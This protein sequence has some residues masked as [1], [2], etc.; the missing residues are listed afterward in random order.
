MAYSSVDEV[1]AFTRHLL[2][3]Q[4]SYNEDTTPTLAEVQNF[5][6]QVSA[7]LDTALA[8]EGFTTPVTQATAALVCDDWVTA[9]VVERVE[10]TQRGV[11]YS[12]AEGT[13]YGAFRNLVSAAQKFAQEN[14]VGFVRLGVPVEIGRVGGLQ[15]TGLTTADDR[16]DPQNSSLEQPKF[17]RGIFNADTEDDE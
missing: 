10:L 8:G 9:R 5:I 16:V 11:G 4:P 3:G 7:I 2:G 1:L 15:F 12:D 17:W 13:R 6:N 14:R